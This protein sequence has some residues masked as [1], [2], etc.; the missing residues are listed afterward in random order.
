MVAGGGSFV[1]EAYATPAAAAKAAGKDAKPKGSHPNQY[2][3]KRLEAE[4]LAAAASTGQGLSG[5][6]GGGAG[7]LRAGGSAAGPYGAGAA[8]HPLGLSAVDAVRE[9]RRG[10]AFDLPSRASSVGFE[11]QTSRAG[12]KRKV[13]ELT[14]ANKRRKKV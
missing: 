5:T 14:N 10:G 9:K 3:K 8:T 2:T 7:A 1:E 11:E 13:D 12:V 6:V 4:A